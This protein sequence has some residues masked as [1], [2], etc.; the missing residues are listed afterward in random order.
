MAL[1]LL[2]ARSERVKRNDY[3]IWSTDKTPTEFQLG[4]SLLFLG[5]VFLADWYRHRRR[6]SLINVI[7]CLLLV[8][9]I[10]QFLLLVFVILGAAFLLRPAILLPSFLLLGCALAIV[11]VLWPQHFTDDA[12]MVL[13]AATA[14]GIGWL[15]ALT[16]ML[17]GW[18]TGTTVGAGGIGGV[19]P[20]GGFLAASA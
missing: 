2:V 19:L 6:D 7:C 17:L 20:R 1:C 3:F 8:G 14:V 12:S 15:V 13:P 10:S 5:L 4:L 11:A 18:V 16:G 9:M